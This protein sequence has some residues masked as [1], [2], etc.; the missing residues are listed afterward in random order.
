MSL[1]ALPVKARRR[2]VV[3][4]VGMVTPLGLS[5]KE[6]MAAVYK[7]A[8]GT[9][10]LDAAN[11]AGYIPSQV[12]EDPKRT[13]A[14]FGLPCQVAAPVCEPPK[15]KEQ[16]SGLFEATSRETR[17]QRMALHAAVEAWNQ[18]NSSGQRKILEADG[19]AVSPKRVGVN[20]GMGMPG[21]QDVADAAWHLYAG[22][23]CHP[24]RIGPFFVPKVLANMISGLISL[25]FG[26]QGPNHSSIT[27]CA[28]GAHSI[29]DA[30]RW[31][32]YGDADV[33]IAGAAEACITPVS[34]AG[35]CRMKAL[36][37]KYNDSPPEASRPFD[38]GRGGFV[39]GEGAGALVL[40]S[41]DG[42]LARGATILG[43]VRGYGMSGDAHHVSTPHPDGVGVQA[44]LEAAL[45]DGGVSASQVGYVN[46]HATGTPIGDEI[47]LAALTRSLAS[48]E[49]AALRQGPLIIS[50]SKGALGHLL[51]AAG[52]VEGIIAL[53]SLRENLAPPT[54]N[55]KDPL[56]HDSS[57][58]ML[59]TT[60]V[61]F[62]TSAVISTSFG[63][64]GT[65]AAL[66]FTKV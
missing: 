36:C 19:G 7:G 55:L 37:T 47:E 31:I 52:A 61:P 57:K 9:K 26:L 6:T 40:E 42:A 53:L 1:G 39:M 62:N 17:P 56:P 41:L 48:D 24:N 46:A 63:F 13:A 3:T 27:A 11:V 64:G 30:A 45:A 2:V 50:S 10:K 20:F 59:N 18:A 38:E 14:L 65:N 12:A 22:T 4:G 29:G 60:T 15:T 44:C 23:D 28:T 54:I 43:E 49:V 35:F 51:G 25:K 66:V 8:S 34:I 5:T 21:L 32:Q 16:K 33:V 58:V